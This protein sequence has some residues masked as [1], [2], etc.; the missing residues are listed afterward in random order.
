MYT[1]YQVM[2]GD[3]LQVISDKFNTSIENLR[4]INSLPFNYDLTVGEQIIVPSISKEPFIYYTIQKGDN[5]YEIARKY[6]VYLNT[7]LRINGLNK[8]DYIYPGEELMI[9]QGNIQTYIV[10]NGET[11][12]DV[13]NKLNTNVDKI[14]ED[15]DSIYLLP[16][17][18][19]IIKK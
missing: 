10:E 15:N 17:Q 7:L 16:G 8:D 5:M 19:L 1:I 2:P 3:N 12:Y 9:P 18:L 13:S 4:K 11:L 6:N 14:I